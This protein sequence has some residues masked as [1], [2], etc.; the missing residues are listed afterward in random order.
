MFEQMGRTISG[1][2]E[3]EF[4]TLALLAGVLVFA[5]ATA[6]MLMR[7]RGRI[8]QSSRRRRRRSHCCAAKRNA[9]SP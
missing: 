3:Q 1:L 2:R 6:V 7:T 4:V 8:A 9:P 5:A